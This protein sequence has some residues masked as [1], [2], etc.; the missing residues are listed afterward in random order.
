MRV[1]RS[2]RRK[3]KI[4]A[5]TSSTAS[6]IA[7]DRLDRALDEKGGV[8]RHLEL[9]ALGQV[10]LDARHFA[11]YRLRH[12]QRVGG[13]LLHHA[14]AQAGPAVAPDHAP[15]VQRAEARLA[16]VAQPHRVAP[17][18]HHDHVVELLGGAQVGFG[19][20]GELAPRRLDAPGGN[21]DVLAPE[22]V[23][24]VLRRERICRQAFPIQPDA[25]RVAAAAADDHRGDARQ[26]L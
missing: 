24:D 17:V 16:D 23:L 5:I 21:L 25:H 19:E 20:H 3:T 1:E 4:T 11:L 22:R 15:L 12:R 10:G 8:E 13:G 7:V 26:R 2:E 14:E 6:P 9:H 18:L